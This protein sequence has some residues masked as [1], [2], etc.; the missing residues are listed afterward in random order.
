M[1]DYFKSQL[2]DTEAANGVEILMQNTI[3]PLILAI[4][5]AIEAII[6]TMHSENFQRYVVI[7]IHFITHHEKNIM[8]NVVKI[9]VTIN[10]YVWMVLWQV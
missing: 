1:L 8:F 10:M 2:K 5:D 9:K 3:N 4:I 6:Q 7:Q